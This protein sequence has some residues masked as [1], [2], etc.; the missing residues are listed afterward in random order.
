MNNLNRF[1]HI[2]REGPD[3]VCISCRLALF[4]N[5]V[6]PFVEEKY[7]KPNMS[8]EIKKHIQCFFNYS[9]STE[10]KW[11]C[12]LC[13]DKIKKRQMSSRAILNKLKVCEVPPELKKLN[14]LEKHLIALRLP[15]MKIVN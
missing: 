12:K 13:S 14:N 2:I 11:I 1:R 9:S 7:I 5:Q 8:Y 4:R 15:F 10:P 6:I 3:Y